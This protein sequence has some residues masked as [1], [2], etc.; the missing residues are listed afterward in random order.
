MI[1]GKIL[2]VVALTALL[3]TT[4]FTRPGLTEQKH[5]RHCAYT[6]WDGSESKRIWATKQMVACFATR[7]KVP[8]NVD[9]ASRVAN[10]ESGYRYWEK[11]GQ[12]WS[13]FQVGEQEW[14]NWQPHWFW[15]V[16]PRAQ[17]TPQGRI[18][19]RF[20]ILRTYSHVIWQAHHGETPWSGWSC[21]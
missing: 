3:F 6:W 11:T 5:E 4:I 2:L 7:L 12:Y 17:R 9:K 8:G 21:Q 13:V 20:N 18:N 16:H 1:R 10:C 15:H 14:L 19:A